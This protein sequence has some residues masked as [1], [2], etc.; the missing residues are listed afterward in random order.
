MF[1]KVFAQILDSSLAENYQTR[2]V[3]E[4]LLKLADK[5]GVVD[6][7]RESI[8]RRTNVPLDIVKAGI[9]AL[10]QPDPTSR[11][12]DMNGKRIFRLDEHRDWGWRIVNFIKYRESATK[13]MLRMA[14]KERKAEWRRRKGFPLASPSQVQSTDK[15]A[16]AERS[17]VRPNVSGTKSGQLVKIPTILNIDSFKNVWVEWIQY[18][19]G[20]KKPGDWNALFQKQLQWLSQFSPQKAIEIVNQSIRNGWQGLFEPKET[21]H[22]NKISSINPAADRRNAGTI[23]SPTDYG[24]AGRRKIARQVNERAGR[25]GQ[26]SAQNEPPPPQVAEHGI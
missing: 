13:E 22:A 6:M 3:F 25:M 7:T 2:L 15:E 26:P 23:K 18:R 21:N 1:A 14:E 19:R 24:E 12:P 4:D 20:M 10:E 17:Q 11:T 9:D 5:D 8:A 16:E